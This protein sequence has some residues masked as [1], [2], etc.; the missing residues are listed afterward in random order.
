MF[1]LYKNHFYNIYHLIVYLS[2]MKRY[3]QIQNSSI[4][5]T[6]KNHPTVCFLLPPD[7]RIIVFFV[8]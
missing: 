8:F 4:I 6:E 2:G 1:M 5:K 7:P 3:L